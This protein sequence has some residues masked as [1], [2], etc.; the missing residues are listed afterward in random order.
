[1]VIYWTRTRSLVRLRRWNGRREK[2]QNKAKDM[3]TSNKDLLEY[4]N[5]QSKTLQAFLHP[6]I[7]WWASMM[8]VALMIELYLKGK[9]LW[10]A[11]SLKS[12]TIILLLLE[13]CITIDH[14]KF[15]L[16]WEMNFK[17]WD[18]NLSV[19]QTSEHR[20]MNMRIQL[21]WLT[22]KTTLRFQMVQDPRSLKSDPS[23]SHILLK[24]NQ[25]K[26]S[27]TVGHLYK[28]YLR[29]ENQKLMWTLLK[30]CQ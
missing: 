19:R 7:T 6:M 2:R 8:T 30:E 1:M 23:T 16:I 13:E 9:T 11:I 29:R 12:T 14:R 20:S 5:L 26:R 4:P 24:W 22:R 15:C 21:H 27:S 10:H 28:E 18:Q 3:S 25:L 17:I